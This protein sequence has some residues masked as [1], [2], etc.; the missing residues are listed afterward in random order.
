[1]KTRPKVPVPSV[2]PASNLGKANSSAS[3]DL[4]S[5]VSFSPSEP[6][7]YSKN[8][9]KGKKLK[10]QEDLSG[11]HS[12]QQALAKCNCCRSGDAWTCK[13][14]FFVRT[15]SW[16]SNILFNG[17]AF[18]GISSPISKIRNALLLEVEQKNV[19]QLVFF[20]FLE[21]MKKRIP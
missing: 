3:R 18:D 4:S 13:S 19:T 20:F 12:V 15:F 17:D 9:N 16:T 11:L 10:Q 8:I 21:K 5:L 2:T 1:M 6:T 7:I 14:Q